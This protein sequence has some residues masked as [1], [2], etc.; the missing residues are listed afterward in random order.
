MS[1][2]RETRNLSASIVPASSETRIGA[3][4]RAVESSDYQRRGRGLNG[5]SLVLPTLGGSWIAGERSY[6]LWAAAWPDLRVH[7][8][9]TLRS[10]VD[11]VQR[12]GPGDSRLKSYPERGIAITG[13]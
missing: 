2:S 5:T 10:R 11:V 9:G 4:G 8:R 12:T 7:R 1:F 13:E 6:R 3:R